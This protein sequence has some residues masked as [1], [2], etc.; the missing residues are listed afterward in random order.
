MDGSELIKQ[1][2]ANNSGQK[3]F[4]LIDPPY[5][6]EGKTLY[7]SYFDK[8]DHIKLRDALL[9]LNQ[10]NRIKWIETYDINQNIYDLYKGSSNCYTYGINY[11]I[12]KAYKANEYIFTNKETLLESTNK[13]KVGNIQA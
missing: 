10:D 8:E 12:T 4:M 2:P 5:Y 13:V 1:L 7:E 9:N 6:K 11:S 3:I